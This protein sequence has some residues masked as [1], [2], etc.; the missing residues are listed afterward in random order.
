MVS[1]WTAPGVIPGRR[2]S[3]RWRDR[4]RLRLRRIRWARNR[5]GNGGAGLSPW[6]YLLLAHLLADFVFQP[7][8]LVR[9]KERPIG[10]G[11]HAAIYGFLT[12]IIA[13]PLFPRWWIVVPVLAAVHYGIDA[14]KGK[15]GHADGP[16]SFVVFLGDQAAHL[17]A[18]A[19]GVALAGVPV[20]A[21][22]SFG[23]P[24]VTAALYYAVPYI[25]TTFAGAIVVYQLALAYHTRS[26]PG[27][28]LSLR[29]RAAGYAERGLALTAVLFLAPMF[30]SIAALWYGVRLIASHHRPGR[31]VE[32]GGSLAMVLVLGWF[33]RQ[34]VGR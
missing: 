16:A 7:Y 1:N 18:L 12:A 6:L 23:P 19:A 22:I 11:I 17:G 24:A 25:A 26:S 9:L 33:F 28:L 30:W 21:E 8:E 3:A 27:D 10:L 32:I 20:G 4:T 15:V 5:L 14:V 2:P 13:V 29:L 31:W 34:G